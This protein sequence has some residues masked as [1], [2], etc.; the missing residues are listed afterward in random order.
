MPLSNGW[1]FCGSMGIC[2]KSTIQALEALYPKLSPGGFAIIDD[3]VLKP[4]AQAVHDFR[5]R[6]GVN[7]PIYDIDGIGSYWRR[8]EKSWATPQRAGAAKG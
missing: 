7:D 1:Q 5:K 4:C 3:Y 6:N 2:T 8:E